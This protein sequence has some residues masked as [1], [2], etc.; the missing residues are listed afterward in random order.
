MG[1]IL[2]RLLV[3]RNIGRAFPTP[4]G[5]IRKLEVTQAHA[6]AVSEAVLV[7]KERYIRQEEAKTLH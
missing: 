6:L 4:L 2:R 5:D 7:C 1:I 3:I